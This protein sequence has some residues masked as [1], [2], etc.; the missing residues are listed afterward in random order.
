MSHNIDFSFDATARSETGKAVARRLR[1]ANKVPGIIYGADKAPLPI[2]LAHN[3]VLKTLGHE[4]VYSH[5]L[6]VN[7][8]NKKEKVVL[9]A[10]ERHHTK[11]Q[12]MHID[13][14]RIKAGEKITMRVPLHFVGEEDCPGVKSGGVVSHLMTDLEVKCLPDSLPE[15]INVNVEGLELDAALHLSDI[16]L[17]KGVELTVELD[18]EHNPTVISVHR[19]KV[20]AEPATE[21]AASEEAQPA[22]EEKPAA[23]EEGTKE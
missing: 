20:E 10:V 1:R 9:K 11:P 7:V 22:E 23:E 13:F 3:E 4:A 14:L 6:T 5:I 21:E 15:F 16:A 18:E 2:T 17:P 8:D 12:I 19:P